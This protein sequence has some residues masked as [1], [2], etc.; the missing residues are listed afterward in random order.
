MP[1][2]KPGYLALENQEALTMELGVMNDKFIMKF[3]KPIEVIVLN[4]AE[5]QALVDTINTYLATRH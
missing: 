3:K 2:I 5:A 4:R 1:N